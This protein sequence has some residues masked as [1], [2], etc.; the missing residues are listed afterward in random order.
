M[1]LSL[2]SP[3]LPGIVANGVTTPV[4][5]IESTCGLQYWL[6]SSWVGE[7]VMPVGKLSEAKNIRLAA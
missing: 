3:M 6:T 2:H 7:A 1:Y 5:L 4:A